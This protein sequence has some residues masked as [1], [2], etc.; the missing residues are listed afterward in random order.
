MDELKAWHNQL[1]EGHRYQLERQADDF[2]GHL[3]VPEQY[4]EQSFS[5]VLPE[6]EE[7]MSE[8]LRLGLPE[9]DALDNAIGW[10]AD[11]I[12]PDFAVARIV[13]EIRL[14]KEKMVRDSRTFGRR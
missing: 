10:I 12:S 9:E 4:L 11:Q 3:L 14:K 7:K 8:C 6:A 13:V 1:S 5:E 2:A